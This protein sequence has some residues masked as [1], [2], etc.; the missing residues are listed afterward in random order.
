MTGAIHWIPLNALMSWKGTS[1]R[2]P[3]KVKT[4]ISKAKPPL[5][6]LQH[7]NYYSKTKSF[8]QLRWQNSRLFP[9]AYGRS[10]LQNIEHGNTQGYCYKH[11]HL[12]FIPSLGA[13]QSSEC[14][15][16][17]YTSETPVLGSSWKFTPYHHRRVNRIA[18][19]C[20]GDIGSTLQ[21]E[22]NSSR[23]V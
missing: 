19:I 21:W 22:A 5:M 2:S 13:S 18:N 7:P 4:V 16:R 23:E 17:Y 14:G 15:S 6:Q 1:L 12:S 11:S 20:V 3:S 9:S 10:L 8:R